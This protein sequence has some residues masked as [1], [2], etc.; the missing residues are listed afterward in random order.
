MFEPR[1]QSAAAADM[2][3][4]ADANPLLEKW[5]GQ[6][7]GLPPFDKVK[8]SDFK[9][10]LEAAMAE[11][12]REIDAIANSRK[13]PTFKNTLLALEKSGDTLNR[14]TTIFGVWSTSLNTGEFPAIQAEMQPKLAAHSDKITQNTKLFKR[15]EA[16]YKGSEMKKLNPE[17]QRLV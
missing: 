13:K 9:P 10:A 7:G 6:W 15:I 17:Q 11:N 4:P 12:L 5:S 8:V 16:V 1:M 14:V 2:A 3:A